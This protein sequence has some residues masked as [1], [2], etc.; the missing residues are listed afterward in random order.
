MPALE[1]LG[2]GGPVVERGE[3]GGLVGG[4]PPEARG[5]VSGALMER[6]VKVLKTTWCDGSYTFLRKR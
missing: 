2:E 6:L 3:V 4:V 1:E 5:L